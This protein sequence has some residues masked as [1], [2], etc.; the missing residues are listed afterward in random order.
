MCGVRLVWEE[1]CCG[2]EALG[3]PGVSWRW[4]GGVGR[5][6]VCTAFV[7][8]G[9]ETGKMGLFPPGVKMLYPSGSW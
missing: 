8:G 1:G 3:E 9:D 7:L 5:C 6:D 2:S 4:Y